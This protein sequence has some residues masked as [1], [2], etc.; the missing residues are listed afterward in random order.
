MAENKV[1]SIPDFTPDEGVQ[2]EPIEEVKEGVTSDGT[3]EEKEKTPDGVQTPA[4]PPAESSEEEQKP[5]PTQVESV[6]TGILTKQITGLQEEREKLLTEI[7]ALRGSR[8]ELKQQEVARVDQKIQQATDELKDLNPDDVNLIS[9][10]MR[11]KGY[12]TKEESSQMF[13]DAVKNEEIN[14]FLDKFPEYKPEND[15]NDLNW[16]ALERQIKTWYRMPNDPRAVGE[17]LL[18]AHRDI[19]KVPSDRGTVEVKKQQMKVASSGSSGVQRSSPQKSV[20]PHLSSLLRT[21]M[22]GWSEEE[23]SKLEQKLPE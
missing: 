16:S 11:A 17:L 4:E 22:H 18:K 14:K 20:N 19:V 5:A 9:R 13:Y 1:G 2:G 21:H 7:Q 23:I 8:R 10:I 15:A 6:D 12:M 3:P